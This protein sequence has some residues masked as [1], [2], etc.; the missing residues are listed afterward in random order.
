MM[1]TRLALTC[2]LETRETPT[3]FL[4]R[5]AARNGISA[6]SD[7]SLDMGI[8]WKNLRLGKLGYV[9]KLLNHKR[10]AAMCRNPR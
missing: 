5:L 8:D 3:S 9:D 10:V 6:A 1:G 2:R 4:S 7:F